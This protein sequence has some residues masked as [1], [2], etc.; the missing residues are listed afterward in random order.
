MKKQITIGLLTA[1]ALILAACGSGGS[2][3]SD[4]TGIVWQWTAMQETLPA[5][6]SVVPDPEN[7]TIVFNDDGT[8][9][10]KADCNQVSGDY[11]MD[12]NNLN[13]SLGASTL[14]A[15][16]WHRSRGSAAMPWKMVSCSSCS[17][18]M[19]GRWTSIMVATLHNSAVLE[20]ESITTFMNIIGAPAIDQ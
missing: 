18:T 15:C 17:R 8:V 2:S 14:M 11:T 13:I 12:G 19:A 9:A 16:V 20:T 4:I 7:Y 6:Q 3:E 10:I 1:F 5:S